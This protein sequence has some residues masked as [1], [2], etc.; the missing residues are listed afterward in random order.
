MT[1]DFR[2]REEL[3]GALRLLAQTIEFPPP[4]DYAERVVRQLTDEAAATSSGTRTGRLRMVPTH[5]MRR[6]LVAAA[7]VLLHHE[8]HRTT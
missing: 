3:E 7:L 6:L 4:P 5:G 2:S 8:H 1:G